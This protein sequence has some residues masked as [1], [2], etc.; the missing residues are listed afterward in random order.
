LAHAS[1]RVTVSETP[2]TALTEIALHIDARAHLYPPSTRPLPR[3][4]ETE[5]KPAQRASSTAQPKPA[6]KVNLDF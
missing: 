6:V 5:A 2:A 4:T 1:L 3:L